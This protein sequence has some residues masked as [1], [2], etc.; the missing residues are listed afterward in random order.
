MH[1]LAATPRFTAEKHSKRKIWKVNLPLSSRFSDLFVNWDLENP[2]E[3]DGSNIFLIKK[4][5]KNVFLKSGQN[6]QFETN[7]L[8]DEK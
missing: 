4:G 1:F 7:L 8:H 2:T 5:I 6:V 3:Y